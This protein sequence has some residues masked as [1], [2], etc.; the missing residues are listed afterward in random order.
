MVKFGGHVEAIREGDFKGTNLY[1]IPYNEIKKMVIQNQPEE[2]TQFIDA[3]QD[4]LSKAEG[5][6]R[7]SQQKFWGHIFSVIGQCAPAIDVRGAHPGKA[8]KLFAGSV[9]P[10]QSQ[11]LLFD[12][13]KIK[14]AATT[15]SEGL[16]KLVKKFDK[17][18]KTQY[19]LKLLPDLFTSSLY[20]GQSILQDSIDLFRELLED[21][22]S[23]QVNSMIR[24]DSDAKH[25]RGVQ[26]RFEELDWLRRLCASLPKYDLLPC[27]VA[28]RGFHNIKDRDDKRP[29]ENSLGAFES[30]W[31]SGIHLCE[32]DIVMTKDE[33]LVLAHD[34]N[35]RR[36]A[37][38]SQSMN[39]S[40]LVSDLTFRELMSIPLKSG[41]RPPLLIDVLRSALAISDESKLVIEIKP[42]NE[43][44]ASALARLLIRHPD[45][46]K[47]VAMIMSF[48]AVTMHRLQAELNIDKADINSPEMRNMINNTSQF[49]LQNR[50]TSFDHFGTMRSFGSQHRALSKLE[51]MGSI[52]LNLSQMNLDFQ[53]QLLSH[54]EEVHTK[55]GATTVAP[56]MIYIPMPKLMLLTV[57]DPPT[58]PCDLQVGI[59]DLSP[60]KSWLRTAD[61]SS[62]DGVY[63]QFK[64][65]MMTPEGAASLRQL[66]E[67]FLIGIWTYS[68]K[69]PD[70]FETLEWLVRQGNCSY[71]N[72]DLPHHFR[73]DITV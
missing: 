5:D 67:H 49:G 40:K 28:H 71:V 7:R 23:S 54:E 3:W 37:L 10:N 44:A 36:L 11:E 4:A 9:E 24:N 27:L 53:H 1:L 57:A 64:D 43:V 30:A 32:C 45:L 59:Q 60:V 33:R 70:D 25:A 63:L 19:S 29:L 66:S 20:S 38:D 39:S 52:G 46:R 69:D 16:R 48:D 8:L 14:G 56:T 26:L 22:S 12:L 58:R 42:G 31:T 68:G 2:S 35:F 41:V 47:A 55:Q 18:R 34:D 51:T 15:N 65:S 17:H 73:K 62:L 6:F 50:L 61:G 21:S 72:T 13:T